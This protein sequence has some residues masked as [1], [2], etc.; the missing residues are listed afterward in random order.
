MNNYLSPGNLLFE[1]TFRAATSSALMADGK[2]KN[3]FLGI[4]DSKVYPKVVDSLG[5]S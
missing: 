2:L 3:T 1:R 5:K 4:L